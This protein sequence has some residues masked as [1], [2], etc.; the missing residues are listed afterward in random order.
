M[1][2]EHLIDLIHAGYTKQEISEL[3]QAEHPAT[4]PEPTKEPAQEPT[5]EPA[6]EPKP[7]PKQEPT[8]E[9]PAYISKLTESME[10][11]R[12]A[13][14]ISNLNGGRQPEKTR[15]VEDILRDAMKEE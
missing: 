14:E 8:Q 1:K 10:A 2:L 11:L 7:E 5:K 15:T 6:S 3:L 9:P 12:K 4:D 13:V